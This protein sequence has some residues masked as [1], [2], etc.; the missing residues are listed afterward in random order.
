[1]DV[2]GFKYIFFWEWFHR[3]VGR[4]IGVI[5]FCP[6][7][8]FFARGYIQ[9]RLKYTLLSMFGLGG[10]QGAI[11]WWMVSSGLKDKN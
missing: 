11:G 3:I 10:L 8:Y 6:M 2:T 5:F 7:V 9:S 4:S 1:M